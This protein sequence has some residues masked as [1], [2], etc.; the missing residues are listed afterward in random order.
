MKNIKQNTTMCC[1]VD[2][3]YYF[4]ESNGFYDDLF[5]EMLDQ[6]ETIKGK[7][8]REEIQY[9]NRDINITLN[10]I[11]FEFLGLKDGYY[12]FRDINAFF[13]IGFKDYIE[14]QRSS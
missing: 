5:L 7:F 2:T 13:K 3:L 12:W 9:E 14:K 1:G 6:F 10:E 8:E 11:A 4:C